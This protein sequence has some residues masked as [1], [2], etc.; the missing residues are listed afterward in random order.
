[1]DDLRLTLQT[2]PP[3]DRRDLGQFI[4]WQRRKATGRQDLRLLEL[5]LSPKEY[6]SEELIKKLYP[7]EP[8]PVAYYA[9]RKRL[10]RYLTD[11]LLLRQR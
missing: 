4:Q 5:L 3:D 7:A 9:L 6:R 11:F 1:M 10:L 2:L 8:N